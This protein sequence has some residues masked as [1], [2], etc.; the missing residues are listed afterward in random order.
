MKQY[1][2]RETPSPESIQE[3]SEFPETLQKLLVYRD[4]TTREKALEFLNPRY[5]L[6]DGKLL[7]DSERAAERIIRAIDAGEKICVYC[8]YDADGIPAG[9][10]FHD[11]FSLIGFT[12]FFIYIPHRHTEGF[13]LHSEALTDIASRGATLV[14]TLDCGISDIGE[15]THGNSLGLDIIIT[16]HH[17]PKETLPP[18]YAIVNPKQTD[19]HYPEKMLCGA[20]VGFKLIQVILEK[21]NFGLTPGKEKWLLDMVGLATISDMVPLRGEN[22]VLAFFGLSVLRKTPRPGLQKLFSL[23][24]TSRHMLSEEDIGFTISPRINVASRLGDPHDAFTMLSERDESRAY[25]YA[26]KLHTLND[27]RKGSVRA[28]TQE[29]NKRIRERHI[30]TEKKVL[31]VGDPRWKPALA[32]L[33]ANSLMQEY[34]KPVFIWGREDGE[35]IKGSARSNGRYGVVDLM[36]HAREVFE[37]FGGHDVSGGFSVSPEKIHLVSDALEKAAE[38]LGERVT[39]ERVWVDLVCNAEELT[40]KLYE[41]ISRLAPF[42]MGNPKPLFKLSLSIFSKPRLFGKHK[43]HLELVLTKKGLKGIYFFAPKKALDHV[44]SGVPYTLYGHFE[45]STFLGR[46]ELRFRIVDIVSE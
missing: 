18:A 23:T 28:L 40:P 13:G 41:E 22:R 16:D 44:E 25:S 17:L 20:G 11:F 33:V 35:L 24:K 2:L 19:C 12:N 10:I 26:E 8:D 21:K 43:E 7:K 30:D 46:S 39:D 45:E 1:S 38:E 27:E 3:L 4:I 36:N 29:I 34:S 42:G 5:E 9:V 14:V 32:G 37:D 31:V 6:H 15:V